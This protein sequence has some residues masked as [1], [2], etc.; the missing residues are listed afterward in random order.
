[1]SSFAL[2]TLVRLD[3]G[4]NR[5]YQTV[6]SLASNYATDPTNCDAEGGLGPD[7]MAYDA[8][9]AAGTTPLPPYYA[10]TQHTFFRAVW[11]MAQLNDASLYPEYAA[12]WKW[13]QTHDLTQSTDPLHGLEILLQE[14]SVCEVMLNDLNFDPTPTFRAE[15]KA[16]LITQCAWRFGSPQWQTD[17]SSF[18]EYGGYGHRR[19][20]LLQIILYMRRITGNPTLYASQ[21]AN[22]FSQTGQHVPALPTDTVFAGFLNNQLGTNP[23]SG[24]FYQYPVANG[25]DASGNP[26]VF[27]GLL[28]VPGAL[29]PAAGIASEKFVVNGAWVETNSNPT[30]P[31]SSWDASYQLI[32]QDGANVAADLYPQY[33]AQL[34]PMAL[35]SAQLALSRQNPDGSINTLGASR[36]GVSGE[37]GRAGEEKPMDL[38]QYMWGMIG[39]A[40]RIAPINP[41]LAATIYASAI[42]ALKNAGRIPATYSSALPAAALSYT[43]PTV[44]LASVIF[45]PAAITGT[46]GA[47]A[48]GV[49]TLAG[50]APA[51][52]SVISL[53]SSAALLTVP[54]AITIPAGQTSASFTAQTSGAV[55]SATTATVTAT[56]GGSSQSGG[57][58]INPPA[59]TLKSISAAT[60]TT[61]GGAVLMG[62]RIYWQGNAATDQIVALSS[63]NDLV[64][65]VPA[66]ETILAGRSS[67]LFLITTFAVQS[68]TEVV[69]TATSADGTVQNATITVTAPPA[70]AAPAPTLVSLTMSPVSLQGGE[71]STTSTVTLSSAALADTEIPLSSS[72]TA[73]AGVPTIVTVPEGQSQVSFPVSTNQVSVDTQVVI[74][75]TLEGISAT[76]ALGVLAPVVEGVTLSAASVVG[77]DATSGV[78]AG[79]TVTLADTAPVDTVIALSSSNTSVATVP[80]NVTIPAGS[81]SADFDITTLATPDAATAIIEAA[82]SASAATAQITVNPVP[83]PT[84]VPTPT[85]AP[86]QASLAVASIGIGTPRAE[87][88]S[89]V[90]AI[91]FEPDPTL[92]AAFTNAW[93]SGQDGLGDATTAYVV[94]QEPNVPQQAIV[95]KITLDADDGVQVG[96]G[97]VTGKFVNGTLH[98]DFTTQLSEFDQNAAGTLEIIRRQCDFLV[99]GDGTPGSGNRGL[100]NVIVGPTWRITRVRRINPTRSL[101]SKLPGGLRYTHTYAIQWCQLVAGQVPAYPVSDQ[102]FCV[103]SSVSTGIPT[104]STGTSSASGL[105]TISTSEPI[106]RPLLAFAEFEFSSASDLACILWTPTGTRS[107]YRFTN[108]GTGT[109][110]LTGGTFPNG[111]LSLE[112]PPGASYTLLDDSTN[113]W[114]I[115]MGYSPVAPTSPNN[116]SV[117]YFDASGSTGHTAETTTNVISAPPKGYNEMHVY[118]VPAALTDV[119]TLPPAANANNS[120]GPLKV[121][122]WNKGTMAYA[123]V[124]AAGSDTIAANTGTQQPADPTQLQAGGMVEVDTDG[125]TDWLFS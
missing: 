84:L 18:S 39:T 35:L 59:T 115:I 8:A 125:T 62:N 43:L 25:V 6:T 109:V 50:P 16:W 56:Y 36:V 17:M 117:T 104:L 75:A 100:L 113:N 33:Q 112:F 9:V 96:A 123:G 52:G 64:A 55:A 65:S 26:I 93:M 47:T 10:D 28:Q 81:L 5:A 77:G 92:L 87:L 70:A 66:S 120:G 12:Q 90:R 45:S 1:M 37:I 11:K 42:N 21:F 57:L 30:P 32:S 82:Q 114:S 31:I 49:V 54:S 68:D 101:P 118:L 73:V 105:I 78:V 38:V 97:D 72:N 121:K 76:D 98:M 58:T 61:T 13:I 46:A 27:S 80:A 107:I 91:L 4:F 34:D 69:I 40:Y 122:I 44:P 94:V 86:A 85:P 110:V 53:A 111:A 3:L 48:T 79:N 83:A 71:S 89:Y 63:S 116:M 108:M 102:G 119:V 22:V 41:T 74:K 14:G 2:P 7:N 95:P 24:T 15:L 124:K 106:A 29:A 23:N 67:Q 99:A 19:S 51:G 88:I 60:P 103:L 20:L